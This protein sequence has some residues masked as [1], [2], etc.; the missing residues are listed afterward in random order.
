MGWCFAADSL[1]VAQRATLT[2]YNRAYVLLAAKRKDV[3]VYSLIFFTNVLRLL[4]ELKISKNELADRAG[5]SIS[6]L[7]DLTNG[8][9]N[10]SLKIMEAIAVALKESLPALLENTDL[11]PAAFSGTPSPHSSPLPAGYIRVSGVLTEY[12]AFTVQ[13]WDQANRKLISESQKK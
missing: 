2:G 4:E 8:K 10:P 13:L 12:Q 7:S 9:A 11:D 5:I 1:R 6:F 3:K